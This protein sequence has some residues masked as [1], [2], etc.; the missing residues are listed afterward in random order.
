MFSW[1]EFTV[2]EK[3]F[4]FVAFPATLILII[5]MIMQIFGFGSEGAGEGLDSDMGLDS[6]IAGEADLSSEVS[7]SLSTLRIFT[8]QGIVAFFAISGWV[9]LWLLIIGVHPVLS[10][11][12]AFVSGLAA[13]FVLSVIFRSLMR[14]QSSGNI[15]LA[16]AVGMPAQVYLKIPGKGK[17]SGKVTVLIQERFR[18]YDAITDEPEDIPSGSQ[19]RI[20]GI[21]SGDTLKVVKL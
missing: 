20:T 14:L 10:I 4:L 11:I 6:D 15:V 21:V 2:L 16:K 3:I 18:E 5:Q 12:V 8:F 17:G 7:T 13:M 1:E 19:V 9:G